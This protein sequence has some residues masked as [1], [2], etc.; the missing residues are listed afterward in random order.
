MVVLLRKSC[1]REENEIKL[2]EKSRWN[3]L[4]LEITLNVFSRLP[5]ESVLDCKRVC[6]TWRN[7]LQFDHDNYFADMHLR[8]PRGLLLQQQQQLFYDDDDDEGPSHEYNIHSKVSLLFFGRYKSFYYVEYD[9][10]DEQSYKTHTRISLDLPIN[11]AIMVGSCNG[12]VCLSIRIENCYQAAY[13]PIYI[14]NPVT[15]ECVNLP[16]FVVNNE[17][18]QGAITMVNGFGYH[19]ST[20]EYKVVRIHYFLNQP[21]LGR[22]HVYTLGRGGG[23]RDKGEINYSLSLSKSILVNGALHWIDLRKAKIIAFNLAD[24][25]FRVL[26]SPPCLGP[27]LTSDSYRLWVLGGGL[28]LVDQSSVRTADIWSFKKKTICS[29]D[30]MKEHE[31]QSWSWSKEFTASIGQINSVHVP[32]AL[33]NSG[34]ILLWYNRRTIVRYDPKTRTSEVI[35]NLDKKL[36]SFQAIPH[37]NSFVSLKALGENAKILGSADGLDSKSMKGADQRKRLIHKL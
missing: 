2:E 24:E 5:V 17:Y 10:N 4:P 1:L 7:L 27:A 23:W 33:T 19:P 16:R 11:A 22:V 28:C 3:D 30:V 25:E 15:R 12:L 32:F 21:S 26:P 31:Y 34:E 29:Y 13:E 36:A 9:E 8:C 35:W 18:K 37:L 20:N 6:K 14:C